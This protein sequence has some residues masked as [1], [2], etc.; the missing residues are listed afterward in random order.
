MLIERYIEQT[1][2]AHHVRI[3]RI[4]RAKGFLEEKELTKL[5]LLPQKN[6]R[7]IISLLITEGLM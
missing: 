7:V 3:C 1:Y 2:G 5:S 6:L 4:L